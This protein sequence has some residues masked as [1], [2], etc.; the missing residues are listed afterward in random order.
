MRRVFL[1]PDSPVLSERNN[2]FKTGRLVILG[3][4]TGQAIGKIYIFGIFLEN[5][6]QKTMILSRQ[7]SCLMYLILLPKSQPVQLKI[8][9]HQKSMCEIAKE[10]H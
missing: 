7:F 2:C 8:E 10:P 4:I 9:N 6:G 5:I 3:T 1:L